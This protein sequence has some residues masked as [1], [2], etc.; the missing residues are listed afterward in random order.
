MHQRAEEMPSQKD[1][2]VDQHGRGDGQAENVAPAEEL[3]RILR[4]GMH[5]HWGEDQTAFLHYLL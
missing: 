4:A 2:D 1:L 3:L 5:R